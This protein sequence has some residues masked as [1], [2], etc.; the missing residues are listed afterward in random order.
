MTYTITAPIT[1]MD[2]YIDTHTN[3]RVYYKSL[4]KETTLRR[5]HI[6]I[7]DLEALPEEFFE[8]KVS[9]SKDQYK[10]GKLAFKYLSYKL[11]EQP[12]TSMLPVDAPIN[13]AMTP[14]QVKQLIASNASFIQAA[15]EGNVSLTINNKAPFQSIY[16]KNE[17][18]SYIL[19]DKAKFPDTNGNPPEYYLRRDVELTITLKRAVNQG[20]A[21]YQM[22]LESS[23]DSKD[24]FQLKQQSQVWGGGSDSSSDVNSNTGFGGGASDIATPDSSIWNV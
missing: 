3:Q 14:E 19:F 17:N 5:V 1:I 7:K 11:G 18:T 13:M 22:T 6:T 4:N 23:Q 20:N 24:V 15:Q 2:S 16:F 21:Y 9:Q 8:I 10:A 12:F